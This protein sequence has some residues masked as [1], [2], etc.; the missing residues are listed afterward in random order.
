MLVAAEVRLLAAVRRRFGAACAARVCASF[1][2]S[3]PVSLSAV[4]HL[5]PRPALP[6]PLVSLVCRAL[7]RRL[8]PRATIALT[9]ARHCAR[10]AVCLG[11]SRACRHRPSLSLRTCFVSLAGALL[12]RCC[13]SCRPSRSTRCSIGVS[14]FR[15]SILCGTMCSTPETS[16]ELYGVEPL[17]YYLVNLAAQLQCR[18]AARRAGAALRR[19]ERLST[20][21]GAA[22][23]VVHLSPAYVWL[24]IML[25]Q[26]HKEERFLFVVYPLLCL[27][28]RRRFVRAVSPLA[29]DAHA[30]TPWRPSR[31]CVLSVSRSASLVLNYRAPLVVWRTLPR[32]R[33]TVAAEPVNVCV[34]QEWHRFPASFFLPNDRVRCATSKPAFTVVAQAVCTVSA[35]HLRSAERHESLQSRGTR[36]LRAARF[37]CD[38]LVDLSLRTANDQRHVD[39]CG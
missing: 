4:L 20:A 9:L 5:C 31:L 23:A 11:L 24:A 18:R 34:G 7:V 36:P 8:S 15:R 35:R 1:S 33:S 32:C 21:R 25:P 10:L 12:P 30:R 3:P 37:D 19:C 17:S 14:C 28:S 6:W 13:S 29:S 39:R 26:P 16:S 38:Y 2:S 27:C 22:H